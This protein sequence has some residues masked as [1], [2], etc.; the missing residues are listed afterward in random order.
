MARM[1]ISTDMSIAS[2]RNDSGTRS[3]ARITRSGF[4]RAGSIVPLMLAFLL[5][6]QIAVLAQQPQPQS[7]GT[8]SGTVIDQ[9]GAA[10]VGARVVL[11][12]GDQSPKQDVQSGNDGQ[13]SFAGVPPGPFQL[14][15]S[16]E[17][18]ATQVYSG[19]LHPGEISVVPQIT[20]PVA[21]AETKIT[22]GLTETELA[23]VQ[24]KDE[25]KQRVLGFVPNFYVSYAPD[26]APL[27]PKQKF[28][29]AWRSTLDPVTFGLTAAA[30]G[31]EQADNQYSRYGG[32][33]QGYGK[34][35]GAAYADTVSSTFI[36]GALLP[37]LL[38]QD[39]RYFYKGTGTFGSRLLYA[40]AN[41]VICKGDNKRWQP[42][43]SYLIGDFASSGLSNLYY[44]SN[45]RGAGL[46][47]ENAAI[48]IGATAAANILQEFVIRKLTPNVLN[49]A[50]SKS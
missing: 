24:L 35:Y 18:F 48:G 5:S 26:A 6:S 29:L 50:A 3:P 44:P 10:V 16:A 11:A 21:P 7:P 8:I 22:V 12:C 15:V 28:E 20:L 23:E 49:R 32:G 14:S 17:G 2:P 47:F 40:L 25:E 1:Q 19:L 33:A 37:S 46:T 42:N 27:T 9:S 31:I 4:L 45:D 38:K 39:P 34:R 41:V 43:Y 30:A 13:F 36:G